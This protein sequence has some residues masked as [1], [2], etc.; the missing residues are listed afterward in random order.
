[1]AVDATMLADALTERTAYEWRVQTDT[2][3]ELCVIS[4]PWGV[5][6]GPRDPATE[7]T[8][9]MLVNI[10]TGN[11]Y[12]LARVALDQ[13]VEEAVALVSTHRSDT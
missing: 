8:W 11:K 5:R 3:A 4:G 2:L 13:I 9:V 10:R 1:M 7:Q 12:T 6:V